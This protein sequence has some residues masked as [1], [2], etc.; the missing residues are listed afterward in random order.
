[1]SLI[2]KTQ[3]L[4]VQCRELGPHLVARGKSHGFWRVAAGSWVIFSCYGMDVH[5]KLKFVQ[6]SQH[7]CLGT[8]DTS[9]MQ[10]TLGRTICM[11]LEI[12]KEVRPPFLVGT[13]I[14]G[15]LSIFKKS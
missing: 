9:R 15:F 1:M 6:R 4:C 8:R 12:K 2:G 3:L 11:P 7:T 5:S 13:V 10:T 14:L